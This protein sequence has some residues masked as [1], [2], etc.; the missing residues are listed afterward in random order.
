MSDLPSVINASFPAMLSYANPDYW[1][2]ALLLTFESHQKGPL[3]RTAGLPIVLGFPESNNKITDLQINWLGLER[4]RFL[5]RG[6]GGL[7][8]VAAALRISHA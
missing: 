7:T 3:E 8:F 6:F 5:L 4:S 1:L 2:G